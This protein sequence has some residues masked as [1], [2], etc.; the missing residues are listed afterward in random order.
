M[1]ILTVF[2]FLFAASFGAEILATE[3][4][5]AKL[6]G[7]AQVDGYS[8]GLDESDWIWLRQKKRLVLG[9]S[10]PDYA[11]FEITANAQ[12]L[13]GITADFAG[14]I[15]QLLHMEID[16]RVFSSRGEVVR[17][18]KNGDVDLL[19]TAN[20]FEV[21]DPDLVESNPYAEDQ[22]VLVTRVGDTEVLSSGLEGK[23]VT[24]LYH[25]LSPE[26]VSK[27]YPEAHIQ[28]HPSLLSAWQP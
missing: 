28:L 5:P 18:L 3:S 4:S 10:Q 13:E 20:G 9:L 21:N 19:G 26:I 11:P 12:G 27:F 23:K 1:R 17:A 25:Y 6:F 16:V 15:G 24:M 2:I 7:R 14:L 8:V 22:P